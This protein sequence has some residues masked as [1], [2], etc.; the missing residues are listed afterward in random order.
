MLDRAIRL[1]RGF[2]GRVG[3]SSIQD[4]ASRI[5]RPK[6][7]ARFD[8]LTSVST[9]MTSTTRLCGEEL[10]RGSLNPG[11]SLEKVGIMVGVIGRSKPVGGRKSARTRWAWRQPLKPSGLPRDDTSRDSRLIT[12]WR[13]IHTQNACPKFVTFCGGRR[14]RMARNCIVLSALHN[15]EAKNE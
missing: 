15:R 9:P 12:T 2:R 14:V 6:F 4:P 1:I 3:G 13:Y 10:P 8:V 7:N 11:D 5:F